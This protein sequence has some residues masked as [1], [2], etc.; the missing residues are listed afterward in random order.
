MT[1]GFP[2]LDENQYFE[3]PHPDTADSDGFLGAGGNLSPGMLI[4]AYRQGIFPWFSEGDP[5]LWFS[6]DPRFVLFPEKLHVPQRL[7]RLL[8]KEVFDVEFN[9]NF[10]QIIGECKNADRPGQRGTWITDG[11]E[12]AYIRLF[13][14]GYIFTAAVF[15]KGSRSLA[16]G[17]YGV[18][19]GRCC[20]GESM[21]GK[22]PD[23]SKYGF[24][25][26]VRQLE[27]EGVAIIDCQ[28]KTAH[29]ERFG[30]EMIPRNVFLEII[31]K[32]QKIKKD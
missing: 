29:L 9:T 1:S 26:I 6:P 23:A 12:K 11:M 27:H 25:K 8:K 10:T 16:G 13:E 24:V 28:M 5:V 18:R 17:V 3:F 15:E 21:F 22:I 14:L 2:Y 19:I 31:N 20:F 7:E 32:N 30:A 4:S